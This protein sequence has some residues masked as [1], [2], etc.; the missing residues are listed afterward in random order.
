MRNLFGYL[1]V[2]ILSALIGLL[3]IPLSTR[4]FDQQLLGQLNLLLSIA[5]VAY[6]VMLLGMDQGYIRFYYENR[7]EDARKSL[8]LRSLCLPAL[9]SLS[10]IVV[11]FVYRNWLGVYFNGNPTLIALALGLLVF[12]LVLLRFTTCFCRV[13]NLL[14]LFGLFSVINVIFSKCIYLLNPGEK[15][16][17]ATLGSIITCTSI[18][19]I[20]CILF[21]LISNNGSIH[22][23]NDDGVFHQRA[24]A[25]RTFAC[26]S[27]PLMPAMLLSTVNANIP[28]FFVRHILDFS[29]V[30]L[31]SMSVTVSSAINF[32]GSG[33]NSFWPTYVFNN[34][35]HKQHVIQLFHR[36]LTF[37]LYFTASILIALRAIVPFFLGE[38]YESSGGL[39]A[40]LIISPLCYSIG[41]TAGIGIHIKKKSYLYLIVYLA[42]LIVNIFLCFALTHL[43]GVTGAA[44]SVSITAIVLLL[45]KA[46]IGN[47]FYDSTGSLRW[48]VGAIVLI[49][50]QAFACQVISNYGITLLVSSICIGL[51]PLVVGVPSFK[52]DCKEIVC[53]ISA[54]LGKRKNDW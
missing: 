22:L 10:F 47:R 11:S 30:G 3:A 18:L 15:N 14:A 26:Y 52:R 32:I 1:A 21:L 12:S 23:K 48:L 53:R 6:M 43:L 5:L 7:S 44:L 45:A 2:S 13:R 34:H 19:S 28:L 29:A 41:E 9:L 39:F 40:I 54:S 38:G 50:T 8:L 49:S 37:C 51:F 27:V 33:I 36:A 35:E 46:V 31:F 20:I 24:V 4:L 25:Y 16:F 42:G 17:S